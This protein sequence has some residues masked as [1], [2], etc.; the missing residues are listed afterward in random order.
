M[1]K[2]MIERSAFIAP[3]GYMTR[4]EALKFLGIS[5]MTIYHYE[6]RGLL[7]PKKIGH[8]SVYANCELEELKKQM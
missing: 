1:K 4:K 7:H 3:N 6:L 5:N 8:Y 2:R